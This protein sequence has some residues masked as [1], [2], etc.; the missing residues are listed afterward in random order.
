[1]DYILNSPAFIINL[2]TQNERLAYSKENI[3]N[4]GFTDIRRF[5]AVKGSDD[6][7]VKIALESLNNPK[8]HDEMETP[9]KIGCLLSHLTLL[10]Y[11]IDQNIQIATIFEDD[12]FFHPQWQTISREYYN[13]TPKDNDKI[14][15]ESCFC[16]HCYTVTLEGAKRLLEAFLNWRYDI[17]NK[18]FPGQNINGIYVVDIMIKFTQMITNLNK[19]E[20]AFTWYCW[21]GTVYPCEFNAIPLSRYNIANSGLVF[22]ALTIFET[23]VNSTPW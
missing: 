5:N 1:M 4:A 14:L 7:Q 19:I 15:T 18:I 2:E 11:I 23:S 8:I 17:F 16:T 3:T 9:G 20:R 6:D 21:N 13:E 22:Q 12:I 10:K